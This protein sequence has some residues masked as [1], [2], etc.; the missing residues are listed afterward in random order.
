MSDT[1]S[2]VS[3]H[4]WCDAAELPPRKFPV[5]YP[6]CTLPRSCACGTALC[7]RTLAAKFP[8][9]S[10]EVNRGAS[11]GDGKRMFDRPPDIVKLLKT[12]IGGGGEQSAAHE[13]YGYFWMSKDDGDTWTDE[14]GSNLVTM[15]AGGGQW[16]DGVK[17]L[18]SGGQGILA[19]T[20]E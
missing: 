1:A 13:H 16:Y 3:T 17:Y 18:N 7:V 9:S 8:F 14:T 6:T 12:S 4:G 2:P 20:L 15:G 19:K 10:A 5:P 11:A